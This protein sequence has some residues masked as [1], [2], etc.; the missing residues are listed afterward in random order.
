MIK[1]LDLK[2]INER[3][4]KEFQEAINK[5]LDSGWYILG[6]Q[7]ECFEKEFAEYVGTSYCI[8]VGSGLDALTLILEGYKELGL[9]STGDE[10]IVPANTFIATILAVIKAGLTPVPVDVNE[11][12]FNLNPEL[13]EK[14]FSSKTKAIIAVHLYGRVADMSRIKEIADKYNLLV[15]EDAAQAHGAMLD[16]L[17]SGNLSDAAAFSFYPGKN[18][19]ALGDGGAITTNNQN[20]AEVI[21]SL[22]NYGSSKKY[23]HEYI[24]TN[25]R[26]DEL[27]ATILRVKLKYLDQD[28]DK[29]RQIASF[30]IENIKN[31]FVRLPKIPE[32]T[33]SHVWHLFVVRVTNRDLFM[34]FM[35]NN[36]IQTQIHYPVPPFKQNALKNYS[37]DNCPVAEKLHKEVVSLPI[38][39]VLTENE[40]KKIAEITSLFSL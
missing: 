14:K 5:V 40:Y 39:P 12:T 28:N 29:R 30:Y 9:L 2:K 31:K 23:I 21:A 37:S 35:K 11:N 32:N 20:L 26:L 3:H 10:V 16:G 13:I 38:S 34:E 1:F 8:G 17:K 25:S 7:V 33:M 22:R 4:R 6:E 19:G 24:G 18:L 15:I 36:G 27:Q